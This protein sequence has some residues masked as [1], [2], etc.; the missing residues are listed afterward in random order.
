MPECPCP[1]LGRDILQKVGAELIFGN[2]LSGILALLSDKETFVS[3]KP[4]W[5]DLVNPE[6]WAT[7]IPGRAKYA[8]PLKIQLK[9]H[10]HY[11]HQRQ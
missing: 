3:E 9:D 4:K 1:L 11:P 2:P 5:L 7:E 8:T 10:S 6:V